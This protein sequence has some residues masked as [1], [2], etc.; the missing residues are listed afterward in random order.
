M[1]NEHAN[2]FKLFATTPKGLELLL[3]DELRALGATTA[4]EKLAGVT[5]TGDLTLAYKACLWSRLAN[6]ILLKLTTVPAATPEALYA[7][8]QTIA[9][10]EH[11]DPTGSLA[12]N[13]VSSH[14]NISHT[15]FGAQ[16]VKD[17]IVDQFRE[18]FQTRPNVSRERPDVS[19][20]VYL[21]RN[22]ATISL[23]L[24][25]D[26]LHKRGYR[27]ATGSAPLKENL[28]AAVLLRAGWPAIA[29]NGGMLMDPMCGS[30]TLLL[31]AALMA[32]DIAPGLART[33]FGFLGWKKHKPAIWKQ[34]HEDAARRREKG[35]ASLPSI[36]GYDIDAN[37]IKIAFENIER[38]NLRGKVHVE[39]RDLSAFAPKAGATSGLIVTNPP[40]GERLGEESELQPLYEILGETFKQSF[41]G[42]QAAVFT[43]NPELAKRMG[44]RA[45]KYYALFNGPIPCQL[46]LFDIVPEKFIDRS[47]AAQNER[48]IRVAQRAIENQDSQAIQMFVNRLRKNFKHLKKQAERNGLASYRVYDADLPEYSFAI[49][50]SADAVQVQEYQAPKTIDENK[51]L[52][53]RQEVLSVLPEVLDRLPSQIFF[54]VQLRQKKMK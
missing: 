25:G 35:L 48:L 49:D 18:K 28:A 32:A 7:G 11:L 21:H 34:L 23:D 31:E 40:Y 6:R 24:S 10:H 45:R 50:I 43:G 46:L 27:L 39:K 29:K 37:A 15:L 33:Y 4:A 17:A 14:S 2:E 13:F 54:S 38:A 5:F 44:I 36:V 26:S 41:S 1:I 16:K 22:E 52:R 3:V 19:I 20:H 8:V 12:V 9:W 30:G 51:V 53:R 42:W 47:P